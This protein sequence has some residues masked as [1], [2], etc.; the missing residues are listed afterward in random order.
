MVPDASAVV[1][2]HSSNSTS[3]VGF[4][5]T[6]KGVGSSLVKVSSA[7]FDSLA[8]DRSTVT[9]KSLSTE[10]QSF[11]NNSIRASTRRTYDSCW[12]RWVGWCCGKQEDPDNP[13]VILLANYLSFLAGEGLS[14]KS[15]AL[16]RSAIATLLEL[17]DERFR[18]LLHS[19]MLNRL[20][21]G[22]FHAT[23]IRPKPKIWD[24]TPVLSYLRSLV[25]TLI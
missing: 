6:P 25:Q 19:N 3:L 15:V 5:T 8:V 22:V 13:T 2:R 20:L 17:K 14:A 11:V 4:T 18:V 10:A 23:P 7:T 1:K 16:H 9:S 24:V 21:K 12:S